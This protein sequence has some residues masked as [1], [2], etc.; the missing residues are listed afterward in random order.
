MEEENWSPASAF[1]KAFDFVTY[2]SSQMSKSGD[3]VSSFIGVA[4]VWIF[5][6][7]VAMIVFPWFSFLF[8]IFK[9]LFFTK[10]HK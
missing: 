6:F 2:A 8:F 9:K 3:P 10:K 7:P 1:S 4:V 5:Y